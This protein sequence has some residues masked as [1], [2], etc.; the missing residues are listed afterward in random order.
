MVHY[1]SI[2]NQPHFRLDRA[3]STIDRL[4]FVL[5]GGAG[6]DPKTDAHIHGGRIT[7]RGADAMESAWDYYQGGKLQGQKALTLARTA[8]APAATATR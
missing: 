2:G 1:C 5:D 4:Q 3:V 8:P 7:L 6:F